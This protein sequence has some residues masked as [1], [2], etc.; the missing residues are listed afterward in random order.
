MMNI[1]EENHSFKLAVMA[2]ETIVFNSKGKKEED[3][4]RGFPTEQEALEYIREKRCAKKL[5]FCRI[6]TIII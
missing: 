5:I 2:S 3:I 6:W 4:P 1:N